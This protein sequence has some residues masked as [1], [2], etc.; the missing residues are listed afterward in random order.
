LFQ[1]LL[2]P[3]DMWELAAILLPMMGAATKSSLSRPLDWLF[4]AE[5]LLT[6]S[7]PG[8]LVHCGRASEG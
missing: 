2:R 1:E 6:L 3:V 5:G 4:G 8:R 7:Y